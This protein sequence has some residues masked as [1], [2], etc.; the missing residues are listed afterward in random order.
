MTQSRPRP[1]VLCILDGWGHREVAEQNAIALGRT[2]VFDRFWREEPHA[3][4]KTSAGDVGLPAGQMGNSEVG[5][6]NIGAGRV[7]RQDLPR[8]DA[9]VADDS[10]AE[11]PLLGDFVRTLGAGGGTCHLMGL[12]SP[13]GVHS[14]QNHLIALAR[15]IA[16]RVVLRTEDVHQAI[17]VAKLCDYPEDVDRFEGLC[18][19]TVIPR[20]EATRNLVQGASSVA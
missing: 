2:P 17:Q 10:L 18:L 15:C 19:K 1:I 20:S 13:G 12:L 7:V 14:H 5:H 11:N 9:A 8:I 16:E 4:L 3:L 6:Q